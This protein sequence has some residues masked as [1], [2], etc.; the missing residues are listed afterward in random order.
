[1]WLRPADISGSAAKSS[2]SGFDVTRRSGRGAAAKV[3]GS[4]HSPNATLAEVI[5]K[6]IYLRQNYHFGPGRIA[7]CLKRYQTYGATA[8]DGTGH[9][10]VAVPSFIGR[11]LARRQP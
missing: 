1:M 2:T 8:A 3:E 9:D 7:M 10:E 4:H 6:I 11:W 5:G